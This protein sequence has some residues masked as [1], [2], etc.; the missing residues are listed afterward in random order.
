MKKDS[1]FW[2]SVIVLSSILILGLLFSIEQSRTFLVALFLRLFLFT[3]HHVIAILSALFLVK[4][5]FIFSIFVKKIALL[6]ATGLSKRY[7]IEKVLTHHVKIH[8]LDHIKDD[9]LRLVHYVKNN[10]RKFP[11]V[12]Q[13]IA[14]M[15][16]VSSLG[17]VGKFMGWMFAIKVFLAKFWSFL[18]AI[19][20]KFA[21][22][23]GYF[24]TDYLW[25]SWIAPIVE[26][27]IFSWVLEWLEKVPFLKKFFQRLYGVM[28]SVL[29]RM[30]RF[31]EKFFHIP[32]R[33]FFAYL[34]KKVKHWI[35]S[36]IDEE[37]LSAWYM[38][39]KIQALK[40]NT[41][42]KLQS[43][44]KQR[45]REKKEYLSA[46]EKHRAKRQQKR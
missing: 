22:A 14:V 1:V 28:H 44:R 36:F 8:F 6:S 45:K 24:F 37:R 7:F 42:E 16:F 5:K 39:Q 17:F 34:A 35:D 4:G 29:K 30:E 26:V 9:V 27:V 3:K 31:T 38:L 15:A 19:F 23:I 25:G 13:I 32:L 2:I 12:K 33:A 20:L 21:T 43:R 41:Y 10:F 40:P 18:L 11:I 46:Y